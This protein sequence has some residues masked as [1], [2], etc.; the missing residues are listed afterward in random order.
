M[1]ALVPIFL[2][3]AAAVA[4]AADVREQLLAIPLSARLGGE[5]TPT[6]PLMDFTAVVAN[7][8][9]DAKAFFSNGNQTFTA[10]WTPAPGRQPVT[11]G[12]GPVFNRESCFDCHLDNGRGAP[13]EG[14]GDALL[15]SLVR[16]SIPGSDE[17]GGPRPVPFYGD[18][19]Q[20]RG[21]PG[22][23][24]EAKPSIAWENVD[25][26][27][28]D[29]TRFSL[30]RPIVSL[31]N[32]A[33]GPLPKDLLTSFR[34]A[35]PMIGLGLLESVPATTLQALA[36]PEDRDGD[37]I[38]GRVNIVWDGGNKSMSEGRFGW[39]ANAPSLV[40]QNA[41]AALGDMGITTPVNRVDLCTDGQDA[42]AAAAKA[43]N[44]SGEPEMG[45][46]LFLRLVVFSRLVAVPPQRDAENPAVKR[47]EEIFRA[48]GCAA[49]HM[50]TLIAGRAADG[51]KP[52]FAEQTFHPFTDLLL[53]DMGEGLADGRPDFLASGS[54]WRTTPLW[55][56]GLTAAVSGHTYFLHDGR[57]R[58]L[59]E[60][61]LWHGGEAETAKEEFRA[62]PAARRA[63]L[64]AFLNSL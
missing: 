51:V 58:N 60:A 9:G 8:D 16:I 33:F 13:P 52:E 43:A 23:P 31:N 5:T 21:I 29:G 57:A 11:D 20:D 34:V 47:G 30:R 7:A 2:L 49:C 48:I 36:D 56:I 42:C 50:P 27:Y 22:V 32:P 17:H 18:Q 6:T 53:H 64:L 3:L 55:G 37:G 35:N 10:T 25:G 39:K 44:P 40:H 38:S 61:V 24:A 45:F 15:S 62:L 28:G 14:P 41:G 63:E 19:I 26:T 1:K 46:D 4:Q 12:L 59:A 54:E